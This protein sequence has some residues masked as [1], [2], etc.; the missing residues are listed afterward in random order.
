MMDDTAGSTKK[1]EAATTRLSIE[2]GNSLLPQ[3]RRVEERFA[4]YINTA[5]EFTQKHQTAAS[6]VLYTVG[7]VGALAGTVA[8]TAG[9]LSVL[10]S[11]AGVGAVALGIEA[12]GAEIVG[13]AFALAGASATSLATATGG[14]VVGGMA[15]AADS[16]L[17]F[18]GALLASPLAP[19]ALGALALG[20]AA[21]LIYRNW[22]PL[23]EFF[24]SWWDGLLSDWNGGLDSF[25]T[26]W[27]TGVDKIRATL[28]SWAG[29]TDATVATGPAL[30]SSNASSN[31]APFR[32]ELH[33]KI[34]SEGKSRVHSMRTSSGFDI[35]TDTSYSMAGG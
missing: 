18:S 7:A 22:E 31:G 5:A 17:L 11:A 19:F 2:L 9:A 28:P 16:V 15:A 34:D 14:A 13:G 12:T 33:V 10:A 4:S 8:L 6:V 29:G 1:L 32:G 20:G 21:T 35:S 27:V 30:P 24:T 23:H 26:S 3:T 25:V